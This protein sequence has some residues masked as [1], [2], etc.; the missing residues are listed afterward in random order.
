[1]GGMPRVKGFITAEQRG[2][3][4]VEVNTEEGLWKMDGIWSSRVDQCGKDS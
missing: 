4:L 3:L 1:M 2:R